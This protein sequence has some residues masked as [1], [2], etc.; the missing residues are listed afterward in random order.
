MK[1]IILYYSY[2]GNTKVLANKKSKELE[3]DIEEIVEVKKPAMIVGLYRVLRQKKTEIRPIK[4]Q[5]DSYDKIIIMSPVWGGSP[6]SPINS[7]IE[8]LPA[9]KKV[10]IIMVSGGGG[11]KK[12]AERTKSLV[13]MKG[14]DVVGYTDL[15]AKKENNEIFS[16]VLD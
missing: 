15:M 10:E 6:V 11:T 16:K 3:A 12:S 9:G 14:C 4:S 13:M 8:C 2:S 5:L 1:T 7:L